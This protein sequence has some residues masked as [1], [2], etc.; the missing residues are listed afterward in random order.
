MKK[1]LKKL[2][3]FG[4]PAAQFNIKGKSVFTSAFS[5]G[6][7]L[8]I[9]VLVLLFVYSRTVKLVTRSDPA[10]FEVSQGLNLL[11]EDAEVYELE[12]NQFSLGVG[13]FYDRYKEWDTE[14]GKI[15][16]ET[17]SYDMS[18]LFDFRTFQ[19]EFDAENGSLD[20]YTT[21]YKVIEFEQC[22]SSD[23]KY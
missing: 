2:D 15:I 6:I 7:G 21:G 23:P 11:D 20:S 13:A 18:V 12:D 1:T 5:G 10:M 22:D 3:F 14:T 9:S 8:V 17:L 19:V 16:S 4:Q